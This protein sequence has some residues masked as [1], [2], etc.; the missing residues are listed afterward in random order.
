MHE[1]REERERRM[2]RGVD[3]AYWQG[4]LAGLMAWAGGGKRMR[5]YDGV[6][7]V[8]S[9]RYWGI[10]LLWSRCAKG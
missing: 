1:R 10:F 4:C 8:H 2:V 5:L 9:M 3:I 7:L 6:I